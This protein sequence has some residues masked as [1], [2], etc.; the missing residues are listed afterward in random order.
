[1]CSG[2][3]KLSEKLSGAAARVRSSIA[4]VGAGWYSTMGDDPYRGD[5][6]V[7]VTARLLGIRLRRDA[8]HWARYDCGRCAIGRRGLTSNGLT[9]TRGRLILRGSACG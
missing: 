1:M 6:R 2:N 3:S 8:E 5:G 7:G 4:A 9:L